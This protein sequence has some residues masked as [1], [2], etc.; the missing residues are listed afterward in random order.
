MIAQLREHNP[1]IYH[2]Q[3]LRLYPLPAV[4]HPILSIAAYSAPQLCCEMPTV[5]P[6]LPVWA[7]GG[8]RR[9]NWIIGILKS[10]CETMGKPID[11]ALPFY[12]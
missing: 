2:Q 1:N 11:Y 6:G 10:E 9:D 5:F 4:P 7:V 8:C 3:Y 12:H